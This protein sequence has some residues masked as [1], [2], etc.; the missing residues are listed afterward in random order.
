MSD[1][2]WKAK[3]LLTIEKKLFFGI[4]TSC[5]SSI[6]DFDCMYFQEWFCLLSKNPTRD[7]KIT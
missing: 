3:K 6:N 2:V 5:V 4:K 1:L 7:L